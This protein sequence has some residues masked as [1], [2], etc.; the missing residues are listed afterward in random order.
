MK[1]K[2][3]IV[4]LVIIA[5]VSCKSSGEYRQER[6][7]SCTNMCK[8]N[9]DIKEFSHEEGGGLIIFGGYTKDKCLCN[10]DNSKVQ[11]P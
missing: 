5:G 1:K 2:I 11:K 7:A 4:F 8:N 10:R 6:I 9:A 3:L